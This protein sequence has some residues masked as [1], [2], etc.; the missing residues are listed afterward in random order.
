MG[1]GEAREG[2]VEKGD[3]VLGRTGKD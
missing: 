1:D 2:R 3:K